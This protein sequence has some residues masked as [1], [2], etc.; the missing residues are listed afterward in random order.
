MKKNKISSIKKTKEKN[1]NVIN[2]EAYKKD[3]LDEKFVSSV[4]NLLKNNKLFL[5][6]FLSK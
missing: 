2:F 6:V 4:I 3:K 1:I 5:K